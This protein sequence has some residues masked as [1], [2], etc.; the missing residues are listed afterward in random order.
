[1]AWLQRAGV[2]G[3]A[4]DPA[5]PNRLQVWLVHYTAARAHAV[6]ARFGAANVAVASQSRAI[7]QAQGRTNDTPPYAGGDRI[8]VPGGSCTSGPTVY[9][10]RANTPYMLTAGHCANVGAAIK[11][12]Q[13]RTMGTVTNKRLCDHC[14]DDETVSG[15]YARLVWG[16]NGILLYEDY[17]RAPTAGN[18]VTVNGSYSGEVRYNRVTNANATV[19][20]GYPDRNRYIRYLFIDQNTQGH[21]ACQAG[22]S[23]APVYTHEGNTDNVIINGVHIA[24]GDGYCYE[25]RIDAIENWFNVHIA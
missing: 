3:W 18:E 4:Q 11:T 17:G 13:G 14:I 2:W 15:N 25:Q 20:I 19:L 21:S 10:N 1:M 16:A 6:T 12:P 22:D 9:G 5:A 24:G 8:E 7:P 23:G